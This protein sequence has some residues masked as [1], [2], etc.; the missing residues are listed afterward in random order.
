[1]PSPYHNNLSRSPINERKRKAKRRLQ[2]KKNV[3]ETKKVTLESPTSISMKNSFII[4]NHD[5]SFDVYY[6]NLMKK[7]KS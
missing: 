2:G 7:K 6:H 3:E 1:M 4:K 5:S